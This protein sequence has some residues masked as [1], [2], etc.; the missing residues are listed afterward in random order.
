MTWDWMNPVTGVPSRGGSKA[1]SL[2]QKLPPK[3]LALHESGHPTAGAQAAHLYAGNLRK[4]GHGFGVPGGGQ[5]RPQLTLAVRKLRKD[6]HG[7]ESCST[8]A[9]VSE[10]ACQ[11]A[12]TWW[13]EKN[14][15]LRV[16][17]APAF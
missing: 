8:G 9:A 15:V 10:R 12:R 17:P 14:G 6:V 11:L 4:S 16:L 7:G 2:M 13:P 5:D 3:R 1:S